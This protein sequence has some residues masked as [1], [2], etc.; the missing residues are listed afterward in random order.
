VIAQ[1]SWRRA[2]ARLLAQEGR[3]DEADRLAAEAVELALATDA[4]TERGETLVEHAQVLRLGGRTADAARQAEAALEL[5]Q[6]KENQ[7]STGLARSVLADV[8]AV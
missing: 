8:I 6:Q 7:A 5:F 4:L 1:F 2:R 3:V